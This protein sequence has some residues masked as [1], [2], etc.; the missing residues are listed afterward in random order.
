MDN[1][2]GKNTQQTGAPTDQVTG[3]ENNNNENLDTKNQNLDLSLG[4]ANDDNKNKSQ[5]SVDDKKNENEDN[6]DNQDV[7]AFE[8]T[9]NT[10]LDFAL[11]FASK[12]GYT[13]DHPYIL[14]AEE[15]D[16]SFLE[17]D[18]ASKGVLGYDK[19]LELAKKGWK[20]MTDAAV[21]QTKAKEA[22]VLE[23]CDNDVE[24]FTRIKD[25]ASKNA[26]QD[27]KD[28]INEMLN[29]GPVQAKAAFNLLRQA[30][31]RS[32]GAVINPK[33]SVQQYSNQQSN[34][35]THITRQ[36]YSEKVHE[37]SKRIGSHNLNNSPEY[38]ALQK[39][40]EMSLRYQG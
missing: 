13:P 28:A 24:L 16:W 1:A 19:Y 38:K 35:F 9:G 32:G 33:S 12:H 29:S 2:N 11:E 17:A 20:E 27:E 14:K 6:K 5:D 3:N 22:A 23:V 18:L 34:S 31:E 36:E 25:F 4:N 39:Q 8:K 15:G 21:E 10:S 40:L 7:I 30:Y 37:L 26:S